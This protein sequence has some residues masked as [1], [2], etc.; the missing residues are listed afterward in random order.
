MD[1]SHEHG[2]QCGE[3]H[4]QSPATGA[5]SARNFDLQELY[6]RTGG[7]INS[8]HRHHVAVNPSVNAPSRN[9]PTDHR[10]IRDLEGL[11]ARSFY[12][13]LD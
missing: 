9:A 12:D 2:A 5:H 6:A 4:S 7:M 8:A 10:R 13:W 3:G 1:R 11:L